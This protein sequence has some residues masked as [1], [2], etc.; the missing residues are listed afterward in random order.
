[1]DADQML[2]QEEVS[3]F[4]AEEI[5]K[6]KRRHR[7]FEDAAESAFPCVDAIL[8]RA[9]AFVRGIGTPDLPERVQ[10]R[11]LGSDKKRVVYVYPDTDRLMLKAVHYCLARTEIGLSPCCLAFRPGFSIRAAFRSVVLRYRPD[12]AC[13]RIDIRNYFNSV[14]VERMVRILTDALEREP[15]VAASVTAMLRNDRVRE[16]GR[17]VRDESKGIMAG[18]PLSPLL[19]NLYLTDFD[20]EAVTWAPVYARYSDDMI[21]FCN[22]GEVKSLWDRIEKALLL[23]GLCRNEEKSVVVSPGEGWEFLGLSYRAGRIGLSEASVRKMKGKISRAARKLY[24]WKVRKEA[25]TERAVRAMIR[26][27]RFK[28]FGTG[29]RDDELTWSRWYFPLISDADDLRE[30]DSYMQSMLRYL[31]T[32][33]H[34][35]KNYKNL[36]YSELQR[37]GYVPLVSA[38]YAMRAGSEKSG[39]KT[40]KTASHRCP[41][42]R[43]EP[44]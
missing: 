19:A 34:T 29:D 3:T 44:T 33:R 32:G 17:V 27:F 43:Q 41:S 42:K 9:Q 11:K 12:Y 26:K 36:P 39:M 13:I 22:P 7:F 38:Y 5:E 28:F 18:M 8:D 25:S 2:R 23:H 16:K 40:I 37:M 1:M 24:R 10:I 14:P 6:E 30:I 35:K 4:L 20:R 21:F 31:E 15:G